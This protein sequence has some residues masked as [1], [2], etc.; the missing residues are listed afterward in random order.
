MVEPRGQPVLAQT[1][2]FDSALV[3]LGQTTLYEQ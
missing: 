3:E 1:K 2:H